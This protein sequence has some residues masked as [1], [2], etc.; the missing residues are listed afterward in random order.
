MNEEYEIVREGLLALLCVGDRINYL[1]TGIGDI[2]T[3][4]TIAVHFV[5][6]ILDDGNLMIRDD[7]GY[8]HYLPL[9]CVEVY[10]GKL[11]AMDIPHLVYAF[12]SPERIERMNNIIENNKLERIYV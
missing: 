9:K 2:D 5:N 8:S 3:N 7:L 6:T 4:Y 1:L 10:K 12:R 11:Y